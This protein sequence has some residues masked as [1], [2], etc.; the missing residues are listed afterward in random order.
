MKR[1]TG[2]SKN[3]VISW[4]PCT[5]VTFEETF[6]TLQ[7]AKAFGD[8]LIGDET[9]SDISIQR[10]RTTNGQKLEARKTDLI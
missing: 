5:G 7:E 6:A 4:R 1:K 9:I 10:S 2:Q 8:H 3:W